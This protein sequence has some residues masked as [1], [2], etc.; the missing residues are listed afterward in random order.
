MCAEHAA[1]QAAGL[2]QREAEKHGISHTGKDGDGYI[3]GDGD[4][5][6]QNGINRHAQDHHESLEAQRK[7]GAQVILT[8]LPPFTGNHRSHR[9]GCDRRDKIDFDHSAEGND[10]DA[11]H[12]R[13]H[14]KT[15]EHRLKPETEKRAQLHIGQT[16][17]DARNCAFNGQLCARYDE[18]GRPA[19]HTLRGFKDAHDDV[20]CVGDDQHRRGGFEHPFEDDERIEIV[21]VVLVDDQLNEF[22]R[23][24][25]GENCAR[26]GDDHMIR[27]TLNHGE[28][29]AV[30]LLR[31]LAYVVGNTGDLGI[32]LVEQPRQVI[33]N[34]L[35]EQL[36]NPFREFIP[37][38]IQRGSPSFGAS[39]AAWVRGSVPVIFFF[40]TF[41]KGWRAAERASCRQAQRR[42]RR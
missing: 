12:Q 21:K 6:H 36:P 13:P 38:K 25:D 5:L 9:D 10:K 7:Q 2:E 15:D 29:A 26:N 4:I 28:N 8:C 41:R 35:D 42:R 24:D 1:G 18:P 39:A 31:G 16:R 3:R 23:C 20:P 40:T 32:H 34:T 14:G 11:D 37:D 27:K 22:E 19:D 30:P 17:F 33:H